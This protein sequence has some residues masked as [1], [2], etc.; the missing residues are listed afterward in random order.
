MM[1]P[2]LLRIRRNFGEGDVARRL[3]EFHKLPIS[4]GIA[5]HPERAN[6]DAMSGGFF[7]IV[8]VRSHAK[9]TAGNEHHRRGRTLVV[10][11]LQESIG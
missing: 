10:L 11:D 3:H 6:G 2:M 9:R 5:I 1:K 8:F 7:R 4:D